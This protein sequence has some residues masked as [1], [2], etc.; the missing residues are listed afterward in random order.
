MNHKKKH[1][2]AGLLLS[3][4]LL[5]L[6]SCSSVASEG[7]R[8]GIHFK[9]LSVAEAYLAYHYG[10]RQY[11]SDTAQINTSGYAEFAGEEA[12]TPGLYLIVLEDD[13]NFEVVIDRQ[14]HFTI[15]VDPD[16]FVG[17]ARFEGSHDNEVFYSYI[18]FL[19]D[20][21]RERQALEHEQ[22]SENTTPRRRDEI[23][24]R[25]VE[26][27]AEVQ[28]KQKRV[29]ED[30]SQS[31]LA[32][33]L[34]AQREPE[35]P[36]PPLL[37]DGRQDVDAMYQIYKS[38]FFD[39]ID[40]SDARLIHTPVYHSRLRVFFNNV[41]VQHPDSVIQ[42]VDRVMDLARANNDVFR[43]T[44]WFLTN[45]A[46]TS[47]VMGMDKV[48]VHM[49]DHYYLSDEVDW[50]P[51]E[52]MERIKNRA[53]EMRPLLLGNVAPDIR[54][55]D[56]NGEQ[57][58]LHGLEAEY[59]VLYFWD[60]ECVF[61]RRATPRIIEAYEQLQDQGV[62]VFSVNTETD[63]EKWLRAIESHPDTW[64]M[65][66]DATNKSRFRDLYAIYAIPKIFILDADKEIIAKDIGA[67]HLENF[68]RQEMR[69]R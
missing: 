60:S 39:H 26:M 45:N 53:D 48:F 23:H 2:I 28:E 57:V 10:N 4:G 34:R 43:Y 41:I 30:E 29:T 33:I 1:L 20:M 37:P 66:H 49:V 14:Q 11:L 25:L 40:F 24:A 8:I 52:R 51:D 16:D 27:D 5:W 32:A 13:R 35:M 6:L 42:E 58:S 31:L 62:K 18:R 3:A 67:E 54:I 38:R 9:D 61:C 22:S 44:L 36:E 21:S 63:T 12:L 68:L 59:L 55:F 47:Q 17:T 65:G 7:H 19:G 64:T 46:E 50:I 56:P 69:R 15:H